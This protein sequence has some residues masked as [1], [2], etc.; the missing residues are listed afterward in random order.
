M[1]IEGWVYIDGKKVRMPMYPYEAPDLGWHIGVE[2]NSPV[3]LLEETKYNQ[4]SDWCEA[5]FDRHTY[6][7]FLKSVWF[8]DA[9]DALLC[10]LKWS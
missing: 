7:M 8:L 5:T 10:K 9:N 4:I 3:S 2:Y 1:A 6:K